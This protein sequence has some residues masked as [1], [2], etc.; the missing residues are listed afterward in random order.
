MAA[1][2]R[3]PVQL[4]REGVR[5]VGLSRAE[6]ASWSSRCVDRAVRDRVWQQVDAD[7]DRR[8]LALWRHLSRRALPPYRTEPLFL[9]AWSAW[10]LGDEP[11]ARVAL[12]CARIQDPTHRASTM[13]GQMLVL[14][15]DPRRL[16]SLAA[17]KPLVDGAV[18]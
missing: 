6:A 7:P 9:L 14:G 15:T 16:P 8:W 13:L 2:G 4:A 10:R 18:R 17:D 1:A 5:R 11:T 12:G 3:G